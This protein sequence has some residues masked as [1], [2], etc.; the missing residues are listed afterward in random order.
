[1]TSKRGIIR[2]SR[3]PKAVAGATSKA[4]EIWDGRWRITGP[5]PEAGV[6]IRALGETALI[7]LGDRRTTDLPRT[8]LIASPSVWKNNELLAAPLAGWPNGWSAE[9]EKGAN[10]FYSSILSH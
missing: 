7:G 5:E 8:S 1:M 2:I 6:E 9:L 10:H 4:G 3:E